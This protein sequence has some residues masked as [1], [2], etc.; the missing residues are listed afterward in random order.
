MGTRIA[1]IFADIRNELKAAND[2]ITSRGAPFRTA[3]PSLSSLNEFWPESKQ[4]VA[5]PHNLQRTVVS[6]ISA[7]FVGL[8]LLMALCASSIP[9]SPDHIGSALFE[10]QYPW[11]LDTCEEF[12]HFFGRWT[13]GSD[14]RP[15]HDETVTLYMQLVE[16]LTIPDSEPINRFSTSRKAALASVNC[17]SRLLDILAISPMSADGQIMLAV[18]LTRLYH[19]TQIDSK[20]SRVLDQ[21]RQPSRVFETGLLKQSVRR[22]CENAEVFDYL[23]K[24]LQVRTMGYYAF[25]VTKNISCRC[26]YGLRR[27]HCLNTPR[28]CKEICAQMA[29]SVSREVR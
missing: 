8:N 20:Q 19:V 21:R 15:L 7:T 2:A 25:D 3:I 17:V 27:V 16:T 6:P 12:W 29:F 11:I 13:T 28:N 9:R 23:E 18:M 22:I 10:Q 24:D 4:F 1:N 26:V 5:V 14:K